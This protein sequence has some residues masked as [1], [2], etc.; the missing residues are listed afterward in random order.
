MGHVHANERGHVSG[1]KVTCMLMRRSRARQCAR[2][3]A[4]RAPRGLT[5][6]AGPA[7]LGLSWG[8]APPVRVPCEA[9]GDC[10][11]GSGTGRG[12]SPGQR[13]G[14]GIVPGQR[15]WGMRLS[16]GQ[17]T[18]RGLSP[19]Q[20]RPAPLTAQPEGSVR[21][22]T[23][24]CFPVWDFEFV[25]ISVQPYPRTG[26]QAVKAS[27]I[28]SPM[29]QNC[30]LWKE[31]QSQAWTGHGRMQDHSKPAESSWILLAAGF[32]LSDK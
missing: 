9:W 17:G 31:E 13:N 3:R 18:G 11:Q 26:A 5:V 21:V 22:F 2:G 10:P 20:R 6:R 28:R 8:A 29:S 23:A 25:Q 7:G 27:P 14:V 15:H 1:K 16:P 30:Q 12:L 24:L 32:A 4:V 19:R